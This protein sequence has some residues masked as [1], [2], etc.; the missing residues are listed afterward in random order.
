MKKS[1]LAI[2]LLLI[3]LSLAA[4]PSIKGVVLDGATLLPLE[5]VNVALLRPGTKVPAAGGPTNGKGEFS[6]TDIPGGKYLIRISFVGYKS[7]FKPVL[8]GTDTLNLG[9]VKLE[10]D[11][12]TLK[13]VSVVGQGS[14]MRMEVDK[15][16]FSVDQS[17]ATAG[18]S[19]S[20]ALRNIPSVDVDNEGNV[21]L[22]NNASVEV[23]INGKPS[24]LTADNRAQVL[25]QMPAENVESVEII[26]N[27]SAKF[28]PEG[29]A[30]IINLVLKQNRKAGYYGSLSTGG[31]YSDGAKLPGGTL[32]A[33]INYNSSKVDAYV[34]LGYR[35]MNMFNDGF[36]SRFTTNPLSHKEDTLKQGYKL[37]PGFGGLFVRAGLD[38]H[39]DKTNTLSL[40]GFGLNG[41]KISN[42]LINYQ[43][44]T[45]SATLKNFSRNIN[46]DGGMKS[47]DLNLDYRHDFDT[48][49]TFLT[50]SCSYSRHDRYSSEQTIQ[51]DWMMNNGAIDLNRNQFVD[52]KS[53]EYLFKVDYT[54][55]LSD[56]SK[57]EAGWQTSIKE[58]QSLADA[59]NNLLHAN[60][61]TFYNDFI[62][63]EQLHAAYLTYGNKF[64]KLNFQ[65][66]VRV[67]NLGRN[68]K[69]N[70]KDLLGNT[71]TQS[72]HFKDTLVVFPSLFL[73]Y[74]LPNKNEIQL[75]YT[76][77]IN[78]PRGQ[79]LSSFKN[80]SDATNISYGN[81][82]LT[83][84]YAYALECN[85][86]KSWD[87][88]TLSASLY[89]RYTDNLIQTVS[90]LHNKIMESTSMNIS[91]SQSSG[92]ELVAKNRLFTLLNLT[93]SFNA[94][95]RTKDAAVYISPYDSSISTFIPSQENFSWTLSEIANLMLGKTLSG[96]ITGKYTAPQL[97]AQGIQKENY[98]IDLGLRKTL[99][100]RK[101][102]LNLTVS[103][104]FNSRRNWSTT[105]GE[106][107][108]QETYT[109][110]HGRM[111]GLSASYNFGNMK[112]KKTE[113][114][115]KEGNVEMNMEGAD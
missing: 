74:S 49:G 6:Y 108:S 75:N 14:Q 47:F 16:V 77:R 24:G 84:E 20:D 55:K 13:E 42:N 112:P 110:F 2:C 69:N 60:I 96:Q 113:K 48:K 92:L 9:E 18:G 70:T 85:Y 88:H 109:L 36:S 81:P 38:Y 61:F 26:T 40:S 53:N 28:N 50:S 45:D 80:Y 76:S 103:D 111:I 10:A 46:T 66:G 35:K 95:Y 15:K 41:A 58:R 44:D 107:Y 101:L 65:G 98:S 64:D 5:F 33:N 11:S 87:E 25:Q 91:Q 56:D 1:I 43:L 97:V 114:M 106:G 73:S 90:F 54:N 17:I 23:W 99:F 19:A 27:P 100:D 86:I 52:G 83:P 34:N 3:S 104:V 21:A 115:K 4:A 63:K 79:Q 67:E 32:G 31:M 22:R 59:T 62:Y 68:I 71:V 72:L 89:Y 82:G 102:N 30:G 29:T 12:K 93:S 57:L 8:L 7:F 39:L 37:Y 105:A 78:R 94:Y 51:T